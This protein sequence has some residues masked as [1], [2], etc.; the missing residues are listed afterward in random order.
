[1]KRVHRTGLTGLCRGWGLE[2]DW[3]WFGV[4]LVLEVGGVQRKESVI[5]LDQH[6]V[7]LL[8]RRGWRGLPSVQRLGWSYWR[9]CRV[10]DVVVCRLSLI[11]GDVWRL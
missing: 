6:R 4:G 9:R 5:L 1:M 11:G 10:L 2:V 7:W 8:G 3:L